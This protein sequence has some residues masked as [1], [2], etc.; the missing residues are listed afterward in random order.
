MCRSPG[1]A[2]AQREA[3]FRPGNVAGLGFM[4]ISGKTREIFSCDNFA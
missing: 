3:D 2:T 1:S 4:G